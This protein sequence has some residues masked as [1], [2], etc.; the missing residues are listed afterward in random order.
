MKGYKYG[1][2]A[3]KLRLATFVLIFKTQNTAVQQEWTICTARAFISLMCYDQMNFLN[4]KNSVRKI[5]HC[6]TGDPRLIV[7]YVHIYVKM[8][9]RMK[10]FFL[11]YTKFLDVI[12]DSV[13][14]RHEVVMS[15]TSSKYALIV[16][17]GIHCFS[18]VLIIIRNVKR[19]TVKSTQTF[20]L[21]FIC[22]FSSVNV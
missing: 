11:N 12:G 3:L 15:T 4:T 5:L 18:S 9:V 19:T 17:I 13:H 14:Q 7:L 6:H 21:F 16:T 22:L 8:R 2:F 1:L 20:F 10:S